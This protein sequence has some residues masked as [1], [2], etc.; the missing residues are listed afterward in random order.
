M[1]KV[2]FGYRAKKTQKHKYTKKLLYKARL[3]HSAGIFEVPGLAVVTDR[4]H[5]RVAHDTLADL[6]E[7]DLKNTIRCGE[8]L[9][10]CRYTLLTL[11][12]L[13]ILFKLL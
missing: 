13:F 1:H 11:F 2:H 7:S 12:S 10:L 9:A 6:P 8:E 4:T 5:G 3:G